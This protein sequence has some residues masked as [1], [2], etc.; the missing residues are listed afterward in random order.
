MEAIGAVLDACVLFSAPLR[1]VL[2]EL[3]VGEVFQARW[4]DRIH[5]EWVRNLLLSRPDLKPESLRRTGN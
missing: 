2:L 3:V 1:D 5:D 4:T